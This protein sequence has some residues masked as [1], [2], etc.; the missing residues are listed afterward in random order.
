MMLKVKHSEIDNSFIAVTHSECSSNS[1][2]F[3]ETD[4][5]K[6]CRYVNAN[7]ACPECGEHTYLGLAVLLNECEAILDTPGVV[8]LESSGYFPK[9]G[10]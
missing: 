9:K 6:H 7:L 2:L 10:R 4:A 8:M 3:I 1:M 5:L